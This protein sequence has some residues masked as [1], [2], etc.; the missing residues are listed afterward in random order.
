MAHAISDWFARLLQTRL[1]TAAAIKGFCAAGGC[2]MSMCCDLRIITASG[3]MGLNELQLG[4]RVP[5]SWAYLMAEIIGPSKAD[6]LCASGALVA[7]QE[8][9]AIGL[10]HI[11]SPQ[12]TTI[13]VIRSALHAL[14]PYLR[15]P[16][17]MRIQYKFERRSQM[18]GQ[19]AA[20]GLTIAKD[21]YAF[22][23]NPQNQERIRS[24]LFGRGG[25]SRM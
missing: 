6:A 7:A 20:E 5:I 11:V 24:I 4:M 17:P 1:V 18:A 2:M 13:D 12:D 16:D 9:A 19:V 14:E 8:C 3:R 21:A 23:G 15:H 25:G 22:F 10:V